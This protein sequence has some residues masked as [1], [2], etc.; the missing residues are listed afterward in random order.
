MPSPKDV[1]T[2]YE[3]STGN[4]VN[5]V[6]VHGEVFSRHATKEEAVEKGR[7]LAMGNK[8]EHV[9]HNMDGTIGKRNSY[10]N[11]PNPPKDKN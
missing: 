7:R 3:S 10:G 8:S 5:K 1:H 11:D 2:V 6:M 4:W 9:I